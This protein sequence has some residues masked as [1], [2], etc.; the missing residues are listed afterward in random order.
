MSRNNFK[1][2]NLFNLLKN[3][4]GISKEYSE[5]IIDSLFEIIT[6]GLKTDEVVKINNFGAFKILH[7]KRRVGRNPKNKRKYA[8]SARKVVVF[9]PSSNLK[10]L[11]NKS[12]G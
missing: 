10:K 3:Q 12:Y 2:V 9:R 4:I 7:K 6:E 11:I 1:K 8:I 5:K